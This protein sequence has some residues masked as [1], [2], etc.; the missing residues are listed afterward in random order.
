[1]IDQYAILTT[2]FPAAI[3][4]V[5]T[6]FKVSEEGVKLHIIQGVAS[7]LVFLA[8]ICVLKLVAFV[9]SN[10]MSTVKWLFVAAFVIVVVMCSLPSAI[11]NIS[12]FQMMLRKFGVMSAD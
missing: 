11:D 8:G 12:W 6:I 4:L 1:M 5:A 3:T 7:A 10:V 2:W 9:V